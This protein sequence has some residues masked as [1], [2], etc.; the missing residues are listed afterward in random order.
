MPSSSSST[1]VSAGSNRH[2]QQQ[3]SHN[4]NE[5]QQQANGDQKK[6][7]APTEA[8]SSPA[9][10]VTSK[11][12]EP[13]SNEDWTTQSNPNTDDQL[14]LNDSASSVTDPSTLEIIPEQQYCEM[15][16]HQLVVLSPKISELLREINLLEEQV[17]PASSSSSHSQ[18]TSS[19][20]INPIEHVRNLAYNIGDPH[21]QAIYGIC[22]HI[23][24]WGF[25]KNDAVALRLLL[26]AS[27]ANVRG[28]A[29]SGDGTSISNAED[30]LSRPG[31]TSTTGNADNRAGN[32]T[33]VA[34]VAAVAVANGSSKVKCPKPGPSITTTTISTSISSTDKS[35]STPDQHEQA[36]T[37]SGNRTPSSEDDTEREI[38][39]PTSEVSA[40]TMAFICE[41]LGGFY[42]IGVGCSPDLNTAF[43][44]LHRSAV[45]GSVD[46]FVGLAAMYE[47]GYGIVK[48]DAM[49]FAMYLKSAEKGHVLSM[50][51][52]GHFYETGKGTS[53]NF[54]EAKYWYHQAAIAKCFPALVRLG[55]LSLHP[56]YETFQ[57]IE[58]AAQTVKS[59]R[60]LHNLAVAYSSTRHGGTPDARKVR[61]LFRKAAKA[62][63]VRSQWLLGKAHS[64]RAQYVENSQ[65]ELRKAFYWYHAAALQGYLPAQWAVSKMYR[66]GQGVEQNLYL[67]ETWQRAANRS[68]FEKCVQELNDPA[69]VSVYS[70]TASN[71]PSWNTVEMEKPLD[72]FA[73]THLNV[74]ASVL[75][76]SMQ[77]T[78]FRDPMP[79]LFSRML[80]PGSENGV[81][82]VPSMS[83]GMFGQST[84]TATTTPS[85]SPNK[86]TN[87]TTTT[88]SPDTS[89]TSPP[90]STTSTTSFQ[91][92]LHHRIPISEFRHYADISSL[93]LCMHMN[94]KT[95]LQDRSRSSPTLEYLERYV[96]THP[97]TTPK[98]MRA[99]R[100]F[101]ASE[102][103]CKESR[104]HEAVDYLCAALRCCTGLVDLENCYNW[105]VLTALSVQ[106]VLA[107]EPND[108]EALLADAFLSML[109]RT[110]EISIVCLERVIQARKE[111]VAAGKPRIRIRGG[112]AAAAA[113]AAAVAAGDVM[114]EDP[115]AYMML[116]GCKAKL[117]LWEEALVD[118]NTAVAVSEDWFEKMPEVYYQ[119]GV[120]YSNLPGHANKERAIEDL[121]KYIGMVH[122]DDRRVPDAHY[123][124]SGCFLALEKVRL[125]VDH[126]AK[127][128]E[129]EALR[130]P[131]FSP[132]I[133]SE[134]KSR[135]TL[136]VKY[137]IVTGSSHVRNIPW[138]RVE[139]KV[140]SMVEGDDMASVSRQCLACHTVGRTKTCAGCRV[141]RYCSTNCQIAH[142]IRGHSAQCGK[143]DQS[144]IAA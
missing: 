115:Y 95:L 8:R 19:P 137:A 112:V 25:V 24:I 56:E 39:A 53:I 26:S 110:P 48:D 76:A 139:G 52:V 77:D 55:I 45:L 127:G 124:I 107:E 6:S 79:P 141:A 131:F 22:L 89:P 17:P 83:S 99:K 136:E 62:G 84:T 54:A 70:L 135:L 34:S 18:S 82:V 59:P 2:H 68:G 33:P 4:T 96:P 120:C 126:F 44:Y 12:A 129:T 60:S 7:V 80:F 11:A 87:T 108:P 71:G 125:V 142:W 51:K 13:V 109:S 29:V 67:A 9:P 20:D 88:T 90:G 28:D 65:S 114:K 74:D 121:R 78:V 106:F 58:K 49:A 128:L 118:F 122:N 36:G 105:R 47:R 93:L 16:I 15:L 102:Q 64:D 5:R 66:A 86:L 37:S 14:A 75:T 140:L 144:A 10:E 117:K 133:N 143:K 35:G 116:G 85:S 43:R 69:M 104:H 31:A 97:V 81:D 27:R 30:I 91:S 38:P 21:A 94:N 32:G 73:S 42:R 92:L 111:A 40:S 3:S 130:Y 134:L 119:R 46:G 123:T 103:A 101:I 57:N 1:T 138:N 113:A 72:H 98:L 41:I 61:K 50:L 132:I 100:L 23:P 63:Y